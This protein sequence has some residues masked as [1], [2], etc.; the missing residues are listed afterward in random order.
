MNLNE[1]DDIIFEKDDVQINKQEFNT[2]N[3]RMCIGD[4]IMHFQLRSLQNKYRDKKNFFYPFMPCTVQFMQAYDVEMTKSSFTGLN[5][6]SYQYVFFPMSDFT[7]ESMSASHWSLLYI[8]NT[9]G[10]MQFKH[11]DS[12]KQCNL[13]IARN[14]AKKIKQIFDLDNFSVEEL[15]CE[16]QT[17]KY[18]CGVYVMAY[19]DTLLQCNDHDEANRQL[20]PSLVNDY[21]K[22]LK[23]YVIECAKILNS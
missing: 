9:K 21:R 23:D 15:R 19:I 22:Y 1:K 11:F 3:D 12:M 13:L 16:N 14:F 7:T 2:L 5:L 18:D 17:N 4:M 10:T 6:K 8:D 20:T